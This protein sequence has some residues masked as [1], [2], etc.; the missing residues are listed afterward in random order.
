LT[1]DR[2]WESASS[3]ETPEHA[4]PGADGGWTDIHSSKFRY[5]KWGSTGAAVGLLALSATFYFVASDAA[6]TLEGE[7]FNSTTCPEGGAPPC[8]AF[9]SKQ[10]SLQARGKRFETLANV[11]L[12]VG[13][14]A[15]A[16]AGLT[17]YWEIKE[18][19]RSRKSTDVAATPVVTDDFVGA[20]ATMR[21]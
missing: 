9:T 6:S 19:R 11:S 21:F 18:S 13:F 16:A 17:W 4:T 14:A 8:R 12:G 3:T 5:A 20:A 10:K 1:D 7:A 2:S 15:A